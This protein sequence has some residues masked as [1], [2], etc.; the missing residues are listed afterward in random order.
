MTDIDGWRGIYKECVCVCLCVRER[1]KKTNKNEM[2]YK[3]NREVDQEVII[4]DF[5]VSS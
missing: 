4:E 5:K 3:T 1:E 2:S